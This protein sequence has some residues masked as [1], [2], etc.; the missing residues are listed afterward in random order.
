MSNENRIMILYELYDSE[1]NW[2]K[3][4][5]KLKMN[6]KSLR[7]HLHYLIKYGIVI[8]NEDI[9]TLTDFGKGL[10]ELN[11]FIKPSD[12]TEALIKNI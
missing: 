11:F 12:I 10:C 2:T 4:H 1:K 6:P 8:K 3:L 5:D 9:Y 7:D